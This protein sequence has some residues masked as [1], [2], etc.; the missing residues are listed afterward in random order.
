MT[1][2]EISIFALTTELLEFFA[3]SLNFGLVG[4]RLALLIGLSVLLSLELIA[5]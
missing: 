2:C 1:G 3:L 4:V 5:N